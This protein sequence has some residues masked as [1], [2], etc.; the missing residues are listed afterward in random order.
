[1]EGLE[2]GEDVVDKHG[3]ALLLLIL[4][5]QHLS[6]RSNVKSQE[7]IKKNTNKRDKNYSCKEM[8]FKREK[9]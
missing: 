2:E 7:I 1:M 4:L 8:N 5:L 9:L 3:V 6:K